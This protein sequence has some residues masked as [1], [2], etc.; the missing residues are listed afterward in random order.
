MAYLQSQKF[1]ANSGIWHVRFHKQTWLPQ[2]L[3]NLGQGTHRLSPMQL[4]K[5]S[6]NS[7]VPIWS[8]SDAL[9]LKLL[10]IKLQTLLPVHKSC[11]HIKGHGGHKFAVRQ[12]HN[13]IAGKKYSFVCKTDI[14]GYYAN[15]DKHQLLSLLSQYIKC[16]IIMNLLGQF[17][18]YSIEYGG[19]FHTPNKGLPRGCPLSPLL[20]GFHLYELDKTLSQQ[21]GT[22]YLRFMDD[23]IIFSKTCGSSNALSP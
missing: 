1:P 6:D 22:R 13:W 7:K 4:V 20:A 5:R 17:L 8:S 16:P 3:S 9:V 15:I 14:K 21:Q 2:L 23:L 18:F 12:T 10:T 11:T 19:N